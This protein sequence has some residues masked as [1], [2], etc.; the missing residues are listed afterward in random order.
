MRDTYQIHQTE[1][2]RRKCNIQAW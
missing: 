1:T 2:A